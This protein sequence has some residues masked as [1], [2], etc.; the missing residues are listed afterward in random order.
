MNFVRS[1]NGLRILVIK[2]LIENAHLL[3]ELIFFLLK[4]NNFLG[5][6]YKHNHYQFN[7]KK[8]ENQIKTNK[9]V[10]TL[11]NDDEKTELKTTEILSEKPTVEL[12]NKLESNEC[13]D[14]D[15]RLIETEELK[16]I[17]FENTEMNKEKTHNDLEVIE[18]NIEE[19]FLNNKDAYICEKDFGKENLNYLNLLNDTVTTSYI[20]PVC[21][22]NKSNMPRK[23]NG[24]LLFIF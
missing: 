4:L 15:E 13:F 10:K 23:K 22:N 21:L 1:R 20:K 12:V 18:F 17:E 19:N 11:C 9:Q 2:S 7:K 16:L 8:D 24:L 6:V 5:F 3:G 14:I